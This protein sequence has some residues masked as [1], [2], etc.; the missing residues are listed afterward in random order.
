MAQLVKNPP[1]M[2]KIWVWSLGWKYPLEEGNLVFWPGEFHGLYSPRSGK[3][4]DTT[5][6]LS[7][8]NIYNI[9]SP[10]QKFSDSSVFYWCMWFKN[11]QSSVLSESSFVIPYSNNPLYCPPLDQILSIKVYRRPTNICISFFIILTSCFL[12]SVFCFTF[13]LLF[14]GFLSLLLAT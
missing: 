8:H 9:Y 14:C 4:S 11:F 1:A 10:V 7:P 5:E 12:F 6:W 3:E 13:Y 2:W